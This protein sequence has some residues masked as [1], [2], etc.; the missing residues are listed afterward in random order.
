LHNPLDQLSESKVCGYLRPD[1]RQFRT[2]SQI[3]RLAPSF[4]L[5]HEQ[6][7]GPMTA[8]LILR[9]ATIRLA[10]ASIVFGD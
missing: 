7:L 3:S 1:F 2:R 6:V 8:M 10:A 5:R 4:D 9:T